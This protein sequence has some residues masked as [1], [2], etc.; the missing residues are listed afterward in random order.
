MAKENSVGNPKKKGRKLLIFI[1]IIVLLA[2]AVVAL[3]IAAGRVAE[4]KLRKFIADS[5]IPYKVSWS[6]VSYKLWSGQ[7]NVSNIT[8]DT[9]G[10]DL[11]TVSKIKKGSPLPLFV[12]INASNLNI[13]VTEEFFG[14]FNVPLSR[15][16]YRSLTGSA[17]ITAELTPDKI[18]NLTVNKLTIQEF[19]TADAKI[20]IG[21][22]SEQMLSELFR[23]LKDKAVLSAWGSFADDGFTN[24]VISFFAADTNTPQD[25]ARTKALEGLNRRMHTQ[26]KTDS[27]Q[28][29]SLAQLY[30]FIDSPNRAS[31]QL[32]SDGETIV[33]LKNL[34]P[35]DNLTG[36]RNTAAWFIDLP[37]S[38]T[39]N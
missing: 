9:A 28:R 37:Q 1:I 33:L 36:W 14:R 35:P 21:S 20:T 13:P 22:V 29:R 32:S 12:M 2:L 11:I 39:A 4:A 38:I 8:V 23:S 7:L 3:Q 25:K 31:T 5:G 24:R 17:T 30:R 10:A 34:F 6:K 26:F 16:G 15:M 27:E 19:G 18:M